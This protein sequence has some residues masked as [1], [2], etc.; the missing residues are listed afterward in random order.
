MPNFL[1]T[2]EIADMLGVETWRVR[3]LFETGSLEEP[4]RFA[5]KRAIPSQLLPL[6]IDEMRRRG[7]L[8]M[9]VIA[10]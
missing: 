6:I 9:E 2:R 8:S 1:T 3:R 5:G 7:W 4:E 10:R